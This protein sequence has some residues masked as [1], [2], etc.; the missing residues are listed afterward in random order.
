MSARRSATARRVA[1]RERP[2]TGS[3]RARELL[4]DSLAQARAQIATTITLILVLATVCFAVLVTTG[5]SA[6]SEARIVEQID[7][8]G[9]RLIALSDNAG[10]ADIRPEAPAQIAGI[11]D[12]TWAFGLGEAVDVTNAVITDGRVAARALVGGLPAEMPLVQGRA[13]LPGE[14]VVGLQAAPTLH[15]GPGLGTIAAPGQDPIAVVGV[16]DASGPLASLANVA[17]VSRAADDVETLRFVYVMASDVTT[18][19]RLEDVLRASTPARNPAALTVETPTGAIAVRDMIAGNLGA[20]AR[21]LMAVVMGV[22]A[23]LIAVTMFAATASRRR[24]FGRRR[25]LGATRSTLVA[26]LLAQTTVGA[27]LGIALGTTAGLIALQ[28][29]AESLPSWQFTAGAAGL[30]LLLT[31]VAAT[32]IALHAATRDPLR[33]L[34]VP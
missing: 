30:A 20:A 14:A 21:Q 10:D 8:A 22:G 16:F 23:V 5:Q 29:T 17:L 15:L 7:G 1:R 28:A 33:I 4:R 31:L 27:V 11:S 32:P 2:I 3:P 6:A 25:A 18:V 34:R 19:E 9:T 13:P 26:G 12:V 24:D